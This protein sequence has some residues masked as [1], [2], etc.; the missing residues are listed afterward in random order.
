[1]KNF[2]KLAIIFFSFI[3]SISLND[4]RPTH[5]FCKKA[6]K[7]DPNLS[8]NFCVRSLEANP[9]TQN[10]TLEELV[11]ISIKLTISNATNISSSISQLLNQKNLDAYTRGALQDC[12]ELYSDANSELNEAMCDLKKKDYFK[13]NIDVSSAMDSSTTCEDGFKE[14]KGMVSPL[15]KEN[16][17]FFQWTAIVLAFINMLS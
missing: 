8:Y 13:A 17:A 10:A 6:A 7:S 5:H 14:K 16:N 11:N 12:L 2:F 15:T 9:K 4:G 1:M 3:Y